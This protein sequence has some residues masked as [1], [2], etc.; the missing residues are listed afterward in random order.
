[1]PILITHIL[2]W[3][4]HTVPKH[5]WWPFLQQAGILLI[6]S[7]SHLWSQQRRPSQ[8]L[9]GHLN[10]I[11]RSVCKVD[12]NYP[13]QISETAYCCIWLLYWLTRRVLLIAGCKYATA[14]GE[15]SQSPWCHGY[16]A[17]FVFI[18]RFDVIFLCSVAPS[19]AC[20]QHLSTVVQQTSWNHV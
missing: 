10:R 17:V 16:T 12:P 20:S 7:P 18:P 9:I 14:L 5:R 15:E 6:M 11:V 13:K 2:R 19:C 4:T 3:S 8:T 1:M